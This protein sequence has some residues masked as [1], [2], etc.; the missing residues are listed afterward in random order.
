MA[1][2]INATEVG[3]P[4]LDAWVFQT[5][6]RMDDE[7]SYAS[8]SQLERVQSGAIGSVFPKNRVERGCG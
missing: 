3:G 8:N 1:A 6:A 7:T 4:H 5:A 2:A